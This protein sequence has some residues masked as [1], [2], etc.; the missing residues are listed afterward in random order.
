M[1]CP[2]GMMGQPQQQDGLGG[3]SACGMSQ[4]LMGQPQQ[5]DGLGGCAACGM[6]QPL[7]GQPQQQ[8]GL[9]GCGAC[10]MSQPM[11]GQPLQAPPDSSLA[12]CQ[13][14]FD[15]GCAGGMMQPAAIG[16][17]PAPDGG[18]AGSGVPQ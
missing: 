8:D 16:Q 2:Q 15:G 18:F 13:A 7:M 17:A 3:C 1:A 11:M 5:Q 6:S 9:G 10:G 4:P 12:G 14:G